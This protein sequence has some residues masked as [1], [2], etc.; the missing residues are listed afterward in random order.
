MA[1][2][3]R[4]AEEMREIATHKRG[5]SIGRLDSLGRIAIEIGRLY[6]HARRKELDT[7]EAYRLVSVLGVMA[8]CL[9]QSQL[10]Q[11]LNDIEAAL[12]AREQPFRPKIVS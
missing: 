4:P 10:E 2:K 9:E 11:R 5:P 12:I 7:I 1:Y 8:K 6:R 3:G